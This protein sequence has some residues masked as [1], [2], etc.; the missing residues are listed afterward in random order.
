MEY[1][2]YLGK[3]V[4]DEDAAVYHGEVVNS[5]DVIT[6]QA[7]DLAEVTKAFQDSVD[8]YL[9]FCHEQGGEPRILSNEAV[10]P[11]SDEWRTE[12]ERRS[13]EFDAGS[14]QPIPWEQVHAESLKRLRGVE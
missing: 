12:I 3:V 9:A 11:L 8:D 4:F 14:V 5:R 1:K 6:F 13:D 10:P 7:G 2:G